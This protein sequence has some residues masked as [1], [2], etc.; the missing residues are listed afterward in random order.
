[1]SATRRRR[2]ACSWLMW[3]LVPLVPASSPVRTMA[4]PTSSAV[5]SPAADARAPSIVLEDLNGDKTLDLVL[6]DHV[7]G[8]ISVRLGQG[9][10]TFGRETRF[11]VGDGAA[12]AAIGDF[13]GDGN[14]DLAIA[15]G[16]SS[17]IHL[18]MGFGDGTF[19]RET[20]LHVGDKPTAL[21]VAD[22]DGDGRQDLVV[23]NSG[24]AGVSL[25]LGA[26]SGGRDE[27][28]FAAERRFKVGAEPEFLAIGDLNGDGR[29][30]LVVANRR[31]NSVSILLGAS[32]GEVFLA[33]KRLRVGKAPDSVVVAD[34][35]SDGKQDL[36][37]VNR[38]S[39]DM[40][41]LIG[42]GGGKFKP[43]CRYG[44]IGPVVSIAA[45]DFDSDTLQDLAVV[46]GGRD[47][48][49]LKSLGDGSFRSGS[50]GLGVSPSFLAV[51][52]F[53]ADGRQDLL[54][55]QEPDGVSTWLG[56]GNGAFVSR[57]ATGSGR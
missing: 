13:D 47:I 18:L 43:E 1:M 39:G 7:Q 23:A 33:Q 16:E 44:F 14:R 4:E 15:D 40:S 55:A 48:Y 36:A 41:V 38:G 11:R 26:G 5:S 25:L 24:S 45:G 17:E 56:R 8:E 46:V 53:D 2:A 35:N 9:D 22:F 31:S 54:T 42:L 37:V 51:G 3:L 49:F 34:F 28:M 52:D 32:G 27:V 50:S 21:A 20:D 6:L 29:P 19:G 57:F 30:D 10:G 12:A